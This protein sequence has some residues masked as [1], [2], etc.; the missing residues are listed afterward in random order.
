MHQTIF[1]MHSFSI[2]DKPIAFQYENTVLDWPS[3]GDH[4]NIELIQQY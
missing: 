4:K 2:Q 1:H 3:H